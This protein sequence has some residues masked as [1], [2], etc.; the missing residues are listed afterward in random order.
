ML[1][2]SIDLIKEKAFKLGKEISRRYSAQ[3]IMNVDYAD[4]IVLLA[5]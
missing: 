4:D 5:N 1:R 2:T 3:T